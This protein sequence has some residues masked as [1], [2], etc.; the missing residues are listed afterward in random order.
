MSP[1]PLYIEP[2]WRS[3]WAGRSYVDQVRAGQ[4]CSDCPDAR[5]SPFAPPWTAF[6][7]LG[8]T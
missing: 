5:P 7:E 6:D 2:R 1:V 4:Q 8:L 3:F